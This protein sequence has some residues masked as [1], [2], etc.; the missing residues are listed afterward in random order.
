MALCRKTDQESDVE[1][2]WFELGVQW[3]SVK[4]ELKKGFVIIYILLKFFSVLD[5]L[6]AFFSA[7]MLTLMIRQVYLS[8]QTEICT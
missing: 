4:K 2:D 3:P 7:S 6:P 5:Y 1:S 8:H